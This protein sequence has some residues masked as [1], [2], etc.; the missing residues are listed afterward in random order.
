MKYE[1][2]K[3]TFFLSIRE[4]KIPNPTNGLLHLQKELNGNFDVQLSVVNLVGN[5][6]LSREASASGTFSQTLDLAEVAA[7][8]IGG[9]VWVGKVVR[10]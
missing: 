5:V 3:R 10:R 8:R 7:G 4:G 9:D 2:E 6:V 1:K